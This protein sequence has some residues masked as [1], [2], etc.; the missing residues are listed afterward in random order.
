MVLVGIIARGII[1]FIAFQI[2]KRLLRGAAKNI[3]RG[4]PPGTVRRGITAG[5]IGGILVGRLGG[6]N[7]VGGGAVGGTQI[8]PNVS[9]KGGKL[10]SYKRR[11]TKLRLTQDYYR[12]K[13]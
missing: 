7:V 3:G 4:A 9:T 11:R 10:R 5:N 2:G 13:R 8:T 1:S 12:S 6:G